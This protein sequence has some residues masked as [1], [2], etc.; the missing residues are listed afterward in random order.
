V[1]EA[2]GSL[3]F[4][5]LILAF[6]EYWLAISLEQPGLMNVVARGMKMDGWM[7]QWID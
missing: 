6:C 3:C 4:S 7:D 2:A 5:P 1:C